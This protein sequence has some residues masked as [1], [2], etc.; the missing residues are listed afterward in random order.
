MDQAT[1]IS[2]DNPAGLFIGAKA[3]VPS[4]V[5]VDAGRENPVW[6]GCADLLRGAG[7]RSTQQRQV[8]GSLLFANGGRHVTAATL[9]AEATAAGIHLSLATVYN[10]LNQFTDAGLLR[11]IGVDGST[12]YFDTNPTGHHHFFVD[13]EDRLLDVPEPGVLIDPLPQPLP[14]YEIA[15]V[16]IVVHLRLKQG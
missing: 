7:L 10:T 4:D 8:L 11:Q 5:V 12:S 3:D 16:D 6:H 13:D 15:G 14:G 1:A 2:V 9:H